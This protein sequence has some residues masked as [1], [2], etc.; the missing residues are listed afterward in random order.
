LRSEDLSSSA[1][2]EL[3]KVTDFL[4]VSRF[5]FDEEPRHNS[6]QDSEKMLPEDRALLE[7]AYRLDAEETRQLLGWEQ[8]GWSV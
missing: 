3:D 7:E 2:A 6:A 8:G 1:Q 5:T 4:G